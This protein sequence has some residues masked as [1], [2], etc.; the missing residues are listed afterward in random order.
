M[1]LNHGDE[2]NLSPFA[3]LQRQIDGMDDIALFEHDTSSL[4]IQLTGYDP[5]P[6]RIPYA[7]VSLVKFPLTDPAPSDMI[8]DR[9]VDARLSMKVCVTD[10]HRNRSDDDVLFWFAME[11]LDDDGVVE[12]LAR[13]I[14]DAGT[15]S[16]SQYWNRLAM[17]QKA[18]IVARC[19][20]PMAAVAAVANR[21]RHGGA[22]C[23]VF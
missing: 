10:R 23:C 18:H 11:V 22:G 16:A 9:T 8:E 4:L 2:E 13:F 17:A 20:G 5:A 15:R 21:Y 3:I 12:N 19:V 6:E 7:L 1:S 14:I